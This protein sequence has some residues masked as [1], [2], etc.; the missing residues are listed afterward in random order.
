LLNTIS[1]IS[2]VSGHYFGH[3]LYISLNMSYSIIL[4]YR[5]GTK[6]PIKELRIR[7]RNTSAQIDIRKVI[8]IKVLENHF[9]YEKQT[10]S[11]ESQHYGWFNQIIK[12]IPDE[13]MSLHNVEYSVETSIRNLLNL[14][15]IESAGDKLWENYISTITNSES[16]INNRKSY[17]DW[18]Q[19]NTLYNPLTKLHLSDNA[20]VREIAKAIKKNPNNTISGADNNLKKLDIQHIYLDV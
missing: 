8:G 17:A 7:V 11:V 16:T 10:L 14:E 5:T 19:N 13:I 6:K 3:Y 4:D 15:K 1:F 12:R 9:N 18:V 2:K 20:I